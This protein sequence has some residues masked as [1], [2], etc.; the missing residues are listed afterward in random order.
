L[1]RPLTSTALYADGV[2]VD[3]NTAEPFDYFTWDLSGYTRSGEHTLQLQAV[4]SFGLEKSSLGLTVT[5]TVVQPESSLNAF[6]A[7]NAQWVILAAVG[8]A[9][10]ILTII[11][12][13]G[14]R[15]RKVSPP[16]K[17]KQGS[18]SNPLTAVVE[19]ETGQTLKRRAA[20]AIKNQGAWLLRLKDDGQPVSSS[21]IPLTTSEILFG[22]DPLHANH[23]LDDPSVS[24][25]H[26]R[27]RLENGRY[28]LSDEGSIAGTWVNYQQLSAPRQ[29]RHGDVFQVGRVAYRFQEHHS[30]VP[31]VPRVTQTRK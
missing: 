4:D 7:R 14:T 26:A 2:L 29:L 18:R 3:E 23:V 5:V 24:P 13:S 22:S 16:G 9:G 12:L 30:T 27:L 19:P 21:P 8:L 15:K 25:R 6:L 10:A 11:L 17:K 20:G 1:V 31:F 28:I